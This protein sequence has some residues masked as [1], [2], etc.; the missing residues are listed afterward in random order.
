MTTEHPDRPKGRAIFI[1]AALIV[2]LAGL[3]AAAPLVDP[4]LLAVFIAI[5]AA[6]AVGFLMR[7]RVP[8]TIAVILVI[9]L[10][11]AAWRVW[12]W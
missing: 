9:L 2:I 12:V 7:R 3:K 11:I 5:I 1:A 6:P 4:L 8:D 10:V